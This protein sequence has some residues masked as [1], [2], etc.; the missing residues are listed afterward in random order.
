MPQ[1]FDFGA[2][3]LLPLQHGDDELS[4]LLFY[5]VW[6]IALKEFDASKLYPNL[7]KT[8]QKVDVKQRH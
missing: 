1:P 3:S 4:P 8:A 2:E 6:V 5:V 7:E